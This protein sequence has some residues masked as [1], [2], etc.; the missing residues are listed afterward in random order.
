MF[1]NMLL[2]K[3]SESTREI[4]I[5]YYY[6]ARSIKFYAAHLT[7]GWED[8]SCGHI[9]SEDRQ[10]LNWQMDLLNSY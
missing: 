1:T 5:R 10:G 4:K 8:I 3:M 6:T 7:M 2:R 9:I